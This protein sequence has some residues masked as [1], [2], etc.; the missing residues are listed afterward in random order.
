MRSK[1]GVVC[2]Q[3]TRLTASR[4][5]AMTALAKKMGLR[6]LLGAPLDNRGGGFWDAAPG[7]LGILYRPGMVVRPASIR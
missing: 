2:L 3:G 6:T 5:R 7:G 4:Q 1:V